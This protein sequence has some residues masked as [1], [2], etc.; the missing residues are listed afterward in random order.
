M[1]PEFREKLAQ[2]PFEEKIRKVVELIR[3][4]RKVKAQRIADEFYERNAIVFRQSRL[5]AWYEGEGGVCI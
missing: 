1:K 4:S 2:L 5:I 3:L